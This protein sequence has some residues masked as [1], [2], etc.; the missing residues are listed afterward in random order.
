MMKSFMLT[1]LFLLSSA[2]YISGADRKPFFCVKSN[3]SQSSFSIY[4]A[5]TTLDGL[6]DYCKENVPLPHG[7]SSS[8]FFVFAGKRIKTDDAFE[9]F[10]AHCEKCNAK[11]DITLYYI[12]PN[13]TS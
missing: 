6:F 13:K 4:V 5:E 12:V 2:A 8:P 1:G 7:C 9:E 3:R 10:K 11:G